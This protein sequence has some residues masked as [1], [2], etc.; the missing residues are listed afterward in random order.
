MGILFLRVYCTFLVWKSWLPDWTVRVP[1]FV[2][3]R[4]CPCVDLISWKDGT[5]DLPHMGS[6]S[7]PLAARGHMTWRHCA[8]FLCLLFS[9]WAYHVYVA[10]CLC[11]SAC[12]HSRVRH[13]L[14]WGDGCWFSAGIW[15]RA[16]CLCSRDERYAPLIRLVLFLVPSLSHALLLLSLSLSPSLSVSLPTSR[17][18][19]MISAAG[20]WY[21][22]SP[23]QFSPP[24]GGAA[25][26][27]HERMLRKDNEFHFV[28]ALTGRVIYL[29]TWGL[30]T[31]S[32][33]ASILPTSLRLSSLF[34]FFLMRHSI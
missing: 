14:I 34:F 21:H 18:L 33:E 29:H 2:F 22:Q 7:C 32:L 10:V 8:H 30:K 12:A 5:L 9:L 28:T 24:H 3:T 4:V 23:L 26:L 1:V 25:S 31:A 17:S 27:Q 11:T 13:A 16:S 19:A 15:P 6:G 20:L